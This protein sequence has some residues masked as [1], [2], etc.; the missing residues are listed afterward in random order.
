MLVA[1]IDTAVGPEEARYEEIAARLTTS[2][3]NLIEESLI[4][5]CEASI[6]EAG[7]FL[8]PQRFD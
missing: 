4:S 5:R 3:P 2:T 8:Q 1:S 6:F 7:L